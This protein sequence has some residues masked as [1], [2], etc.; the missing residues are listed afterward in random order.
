MKVSKFKLSKYYEHILT[1][2]ISYH[3]LH[4]NT[5]GDI[6]WVARKFFAW[7]V[8]GDCLDLESVKADHISKLMVRLDRAKP[9]LD[10]RIFVGKS[11]RQVQLLLELFLQILLSW[12]CQTEHFQVQVRI[13]YLRRLP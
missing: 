10:R 9:E 13:R 12:S 2:Y 7:L 8:E 5:R 6:I 4:P 3:D 11:V 1:D